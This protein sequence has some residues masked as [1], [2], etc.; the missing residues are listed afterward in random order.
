MENA[1]QTPAGY[2]ELL[3][4]LKTR[5]SAAQFRA[6]FAV[7]RELILFYWSMS[8]EILTREDA[9]G[10]GAKIVKRLDHDLQTESPD[11]EG[12]NAR[13]LKYMRAVAAA[14]CT[15]AAGPS[16]GLARPAENPD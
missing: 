7:N 6:A 13:S 3:Q 10:W 11:V 4:E 15:I 8:R 1:L 2:A 5:A 16:Y 14:C 12:F 9:E